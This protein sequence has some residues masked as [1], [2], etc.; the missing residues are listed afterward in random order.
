M[1]TTITT[2]FLSA[3][4]ILAVLLFLIFQEWDRQ[5]KLK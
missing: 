5:D 3:V 2:K 4:F 1:I